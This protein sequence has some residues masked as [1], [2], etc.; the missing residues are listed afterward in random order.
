MNSA[1]LLAG[2]TAKMLVQGLDDSQG[3]RAVDAVVDALAFTS[4]AHQL[5]ISQHSELLGQGG[6]YDAQQLLQLAHPFFPL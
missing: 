6:L 1:V 4:R 3:L 5:L 2:L